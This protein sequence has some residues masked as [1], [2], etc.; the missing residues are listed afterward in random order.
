PLIRPARFLMGGGAALVLACSQPASRA[1]EPRVVLEQQVS[2]TT[3]LLQAVS[4]VNES[5]AWV[6]GHAGTWARTLDGGRTWQAGKVP[7]GDSL[8]FRDVHALSAEL[9]WLMSAGPGTLSRIYR[10]EDGGASWALQ[11]TNSVPTAFYDC[12]SFWD[13]RRGLAYSDQVDGRVMLLA[14][15]DGGESWNLVPQHRLPRALPD[16][17]GFAA[18]GT[19]LVTRP[20]GLAW[21]ATGNGPRSRVLRTDDYGATWSVTDVPVPAG[22]AAGLATITFRDD[23]NG[24]ALGG[25]IGSPEVHTDNVAV[26]T[27]GG[28]SWRISGRTAWPGAAYGAAYVP[29]SVNALVA[30]SPKGA[31]ISRDDGR[32]WAVLD[33]V[34]YWGIG[35]SP[36]GAGW[37]TGPRGRIA[38]VNIR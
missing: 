24:A 3:A 16:E 25:T 14:T 15:T 26:T 10:T 22:E 9:A 1:P 35:F 19:C 7:G 18:S 5:V 4:A 12:M 6:S 37:I 28:R 38:R 21:I 13:E 30:V 17:G 32:T 8:Q 34:S 27:D 36:D 33:S 31:G 23:R 29:G 11:F 20:G 2:G